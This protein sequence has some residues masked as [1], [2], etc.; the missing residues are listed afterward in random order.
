MKHVT[1][2]ISLLLL[3]VTAFAQTYSNA[4]LNG[5]YSVQISLV[6]YDVWSK[7]V[8]YVCAGTTW[9]FTGGGQTVS[10]K[11]VVGP[12][13]MNFNGAGSFTGTGT[14]AG[15]FNP[16]KSNATVTITHDVYCN[17]IINNGYA[18]FDR[19]TSSSFT[20]TYNVRSDGTGTLAVTGVTSGTCQLA[21]TTASG[22]SNTMMFTFFRGG[23]VDGAGV[24]VRQVLA[25]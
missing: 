7:T 10:S 6:Q 9:T 12:G 14:T 15:N 18:V 11:N 20:G 4:N 16:S 23:M 5:A 3:S 22:V 13:V 19:S 17:P 25:E 2:A 1:L 24:A 21:G 8:S